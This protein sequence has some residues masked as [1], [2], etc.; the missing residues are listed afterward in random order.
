MFPHNKWT[1][2]ASFKHVVPVA[3][4]RQHSD[5]AHGDTS[6]TQRAGIVK[7]PRDGYSTHLCVVDTSVDI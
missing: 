5:D 1:T 4:H 7:E 2:G 6:E 3:R